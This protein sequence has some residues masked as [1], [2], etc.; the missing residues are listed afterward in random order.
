MKRKRLLI[1]L[2]VVLLLIVVVGALM[3]F[4]VIDVSQI[5][6]NTGEPVVST[7]EYQVAIPGNI[8]TNIKNS[9]RFVRCEIV[10]ILNNEKESTKLVS[11]TF[12]VKDVMLEILRGTEE[13]EFRADDIQDRISEKLITKMNELHEYES[14]TK[15]YYKQLITQ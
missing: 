1:I 8:I 2:L 12:K 14:I 6:G 3:F 9:R 15:V 10:L 13:L 7:K 4:G 5:L 11:E